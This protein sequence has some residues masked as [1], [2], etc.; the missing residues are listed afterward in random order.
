MGAAFSDA[1]SLTAWMRETL[2]L[3]YGAE[4]TAQLRPLKPGQHGLTLLPFW[5][6]ERSYGWRPDARGTIQGLSLSTTALDIYQAALEAV[7]LRL[8]RALEALDGVFGGVEEIVA[9]G[10]ALEG[11]SPWAQT[12][13]D[14]LNRPIHVADVAEAT[15][16][17]V[18]WYAM[19]PNL[20]LAP[21]DPAA[22]VFEPN[23]EHVGIYDELF[24]RQEGLYG[25][26]L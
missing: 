11:D 17:G 15:S 25:L 12:L 2:R 10:G 19:H 8:R 20:E 5:G 9:S 21:P 7:A 23:P 16:R 18:A 4:L 14:A 13:A 6:G 1:G 3:P 22:R 26:G 24:E